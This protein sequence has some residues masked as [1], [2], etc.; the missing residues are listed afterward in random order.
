M[1][2]S[3][4]KLIL[5]RVHRERVALCRELE[6]DDVLFDFNEE[7]KTQSDVIYVPTLKGNSGEWTGF[8]TQKPIA[9]YQRLHG[10]Q[11]RRRFRP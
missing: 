7:F 1:K 8:K 11:Q 2:E 5:R 10:I 4:D 6:D 9:L 3:R